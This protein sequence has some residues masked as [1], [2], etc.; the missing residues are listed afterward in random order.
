MSLDFTDDDIQAL[1]TVANADCSASWIA[2]TALEHVEGH[3]SD[4]ENTDVEADVEA[5]NEPDGSVFAY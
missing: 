4:M 1:K 2:E 3:S 5:T